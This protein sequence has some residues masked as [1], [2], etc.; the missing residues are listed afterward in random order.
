MKIYA[1]YWN[2]QI[3]NKKFSTVKKAKQDS[4]RVIVQKEKGN[5]D[6]AII[7]GSVFDI[8]GKE[9][10][11][12][13]DIW[14]GDVRYPCD[15]NGDFSISLQPGKYQLLARGF[16]YKSYQYNLKIKRGDLIKIFFYLMPVKFNG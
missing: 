2:I 14:I 8:P 11:Q 16:S 12:I 1:E 9:K 10:I 13:S 15:S 3:K 4:G 7:E 5:P 6:L